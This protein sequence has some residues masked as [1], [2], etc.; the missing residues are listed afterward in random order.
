MPL[1]VRIVIVGGGLAA[2]SLVQALRR[3]DFAGELVVL[4]GEDAVPYDRPPL[5]K[6]VLRGER[7]APLLVEAAD[8]ADLEVDLRLGCRAGGLDPQGRRVLLAGGASLPYDALVV[9]TGAAPRHL[10]GLSGDGVHVLRT[11]EDATAL[12]AAIRRAGQVVIVGGGFIGCEVAASARA[13][14]AQVVLLETLGLPLVRALG[15]AVAAELTAVHVGAGV[16]VRAGTRIEAVTGT[17]ADRLLALSDGT[18]VPGPVVLVG[19]GVTADTGWLAGS[20]ITLD[21]GVVCDAG[22]RSSLPG[23]W[24]VGDASRWWLPALAAHRRIEHWT[25]ALE[26]AEVLAANLLGADAAHDPVPYVWSEQY[27]VT[28]QV[29][30]LPAPDDDVTVLR[31]GPAADLLAAVYGRDGRCTGV[32]VGGAPRVFSRLRKLL[33]AGAPYDD[34]VVSASL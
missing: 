6:D 10:A 18:T 24:A 17:G 2:V 16:D 19:I 4:S 28:L 3:L 21:D 30:G 13:L 20:G 31:V 32:L 14:G 25:N 23:V 8:W 15:P 22:G 12:G 9:A 7:D 27:G 1:P 26:Q 11:Q 33:A 34:V 5:S 29:A